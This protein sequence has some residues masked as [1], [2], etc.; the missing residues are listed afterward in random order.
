MPL[1]PFKI[2][3]NSQL[4]SL[5]YLYKNILN[6]ILV[7]YCFASGCLPSI[8]APIDI[9]CRDTINGIS[10]VG[11]DYNVSISGDDFER[12]QDC[13]ELSTLVGLPG[14]W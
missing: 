2:R 13:S 9:P 7:L 4:V 6:N 8:P 1:D 3:L 14:T 12:S 10:A 5:L 11:D